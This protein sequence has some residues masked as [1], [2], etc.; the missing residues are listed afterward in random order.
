M[1]VFRVP[2]DERIDYFFNSCARGFGVL[3]SSPVSHFKQMRAT[4]R[5]VAQSTQA[6]C[7]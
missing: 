4:Y 7:N 2:G 6:V 5:A 3:G 1:W